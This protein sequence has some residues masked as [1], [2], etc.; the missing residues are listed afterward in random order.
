MPHDCEAEAGSTTIAA[1]ATIDPV[2][3]FK[4]AFNLRLGYPRALVG[5][6]DGEIPSLDR[7]GNLYRPVTV[8]VSQRV[9]QEIGE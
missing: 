6:D 9:V 7:G 5:D 1:S 8:G 4:D 2:E 3:S